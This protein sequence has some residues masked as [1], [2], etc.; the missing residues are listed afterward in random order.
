MTTSSNRQAKSSYPTVS[1]DTLLSISK[2]T[3]TPFPGLPS[4]LDVASEIFSKEPIKP[5]NYE[6]F[7]S[8]S[9]PNDV[10]LTPYVANPRQQKP[11]IQ[12]KRYIIPKSPFSA[13][14]LASNLNDKVWYYIDE[15]ENTQGP[16]SSGDMD[17]WFDGGYFFNELLIRFKEHGEFAKLSEKLGKQQEYQQQQNYYNDSNPKP[18]GIGRNNSGSNQQGGRTFESKDK[19]ERRTEDK[20]AAQGGFVRGAKREAK[21]ELPL[22]LSPTE[23][24]KQSSEESNQFFFDLCV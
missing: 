21:E 22:I 20:P 24:P 11:V 23:V 13:S 4:L 18:F 15:E 9:D 2:K 5:E 17:S 1:K 8:I 7:N 3:I 10:F 12:K 16:F 19:F 6:R 14:G